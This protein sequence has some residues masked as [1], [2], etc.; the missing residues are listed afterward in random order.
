MRNSKGGSVGGVVGDGVQLLYED[1][2]F[3]DF[4]RE[5]KEGL[6]FFFFFFFF[7]W[8]FLFLLS[9]TNLIYSL[10]YSLSENYFIYRYKSI[11]RVSL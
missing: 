10:Y 1:T 3:V 11:N 8:W 9:L 5:V 2:G 4:G 6:F 7:F